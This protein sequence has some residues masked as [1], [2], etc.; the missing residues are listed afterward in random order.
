MEAEEATRRIRG[1]NNGDRLCE[2]KT[3]E[4][5]GQSWDDAVVAS[6]AT[7]QWEWRTP[8]NRQSS[9]CAAGG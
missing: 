4:E 5:K 7:L 2:Y 6:I 8:W 1:N 3:E 9:R